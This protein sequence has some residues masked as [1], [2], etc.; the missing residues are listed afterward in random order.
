[1]SITKYLFLANSL[2]SC[3]IPT[4]QT[5][6]AEQKSVFVVQPLGKSNRILILTYLE[7]LKSVSSN[8]TDS[9]VVPI[10]VP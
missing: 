9:T 3:L 8:P 4:L 5:S 7:F 1:M 2:T 6:A 10:C